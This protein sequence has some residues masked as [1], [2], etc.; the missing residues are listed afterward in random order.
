MSKNG[1]GELKTH[2]F[3]VQFANDNTRAWQNLN[4]KILKKNYLYSFTPLFV[5]EKNVNEIALLKFYLAT[6]CFLVTATST[7]CSLAFEDRID[8]KNS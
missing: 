7:V 2:H 4:D 5:Y 1:S 3:V 6:H 8:L